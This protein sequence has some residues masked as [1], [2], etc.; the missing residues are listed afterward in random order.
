MNIQPL[1]DAQRIILVGHQ[2]IDPDSWGSQ[3]ALYQVLRAL[4][5]D[6][7][8]LNHEQVDSNLAPFYKN[9][10]QWVPEPDLVVLLDC[11]SLDRVG[12]MGPVIRDMSCPVMVI[13]HHLYEGDEWWNF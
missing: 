3:A 7:L 2:N 10:G 11:S 12:S 13:D 4:D 6:L 9:G 5:K 8:I 1:I